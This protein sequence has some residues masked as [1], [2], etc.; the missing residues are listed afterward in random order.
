MLLAGASGALASGVGY[1]VWHVA[2]GGITATRAATVQ[3]SVP[4]LAAIGIGVVFVSEPVTPRLALSAFLILGG[5][6]LAVSGTRL[7]TRPP[8]S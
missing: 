1:A 6:G 2:L 4:V 3:L 5:V 7:L 8:T